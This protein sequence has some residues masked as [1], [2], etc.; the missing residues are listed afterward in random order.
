[1]GNAASANQDKISSPSYFSSI[2][3]F[4]S[5]T[6]NGDRQLLT[7]HFGV[8]D[9]SERH[10]HVHHHPD[11]Q[12]FQNTFS[13]LSQKTRFHDQLTFWW[14]VIYWPI[15]NYTG[16]LLHEEFGAKYT[17]DSASWAPL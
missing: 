6:S 5:V 7:R 14:S 2:G 1:M 4:T 11:A 12:V 16:G 3:L 8:R 13:G 10:L 17:Q 9:F 15:C